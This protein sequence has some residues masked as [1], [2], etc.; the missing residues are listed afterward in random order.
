MRL[1][2]RAQLE[3]AS[4]AHVN[5]LPQPHASTSTPAPS[6]P[7]LRRESTCVHSLTHTHASCSSPRAPGNGDLPGTQQ[8][9]AGYTCP[10]GKPGRQGLCS[11]GSHQVGEPVRGPVYLHIICMC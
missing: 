1:A 2:G 10:T 5:M 3:V 9:S 8:G 6:H 11:R 4:H 7:Q